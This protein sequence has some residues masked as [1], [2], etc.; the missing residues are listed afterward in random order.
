MQIHKHINMLH[1][2]HRYGTWSVGIGA[3]HR[4]LCFDTPSFGVSFHN[5]H[6]FMIITTFEHTTE[7]IVP[8]RFI[9]NCITAVLNVPTLLVCLNPR[10][11][12]CLLLELYP[13]W[14]VLVTCSPLTVRLPRLFGL[15]LRHR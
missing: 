7:T 8:I 12:D 14:W 6:T 2:V 1:I 3:K 11:Q 4:R 15:L 5:L 10:S 9:S 13:L